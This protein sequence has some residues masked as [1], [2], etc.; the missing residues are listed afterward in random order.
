MKDGQLAHFEVETHLL[1]SSVTHRPF[2]IGKVWIPM[3]VFYDLFRFFRLLLDTPSYL[4]DHYPMGFW[5]FILCLFLASANDLTKDLIKAIMTG[6]NPMIEATLAKGVDVNA[7]TGKGVT[8]LMLAALQGNHKVVNSLLAKGALVDEQDASGL[9]ALMAAARLGHLD[10]VKTLVA[11]KA[12]AKLKS[13]SGKTALDLA[14]DSGKAD[15]EGFLN[16]I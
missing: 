7:K 4:L 2:L 16:G 15:V 12:N 5:G 11:S 14:R 10:I 6:D 13:Q 3:N 8:P 9:T 1:E